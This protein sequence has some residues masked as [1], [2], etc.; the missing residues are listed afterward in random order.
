MVTF[1]E[2]LQQAAESNPDVSVEVQPDEPEPSE[3]VQVAYE[4]SSWRVGDVRRHKKVFEGM[5]GENGKI[6]FIFIN[7]LP[8]TDYYVLQSRFTV[9]FL[10][11]QM[12][13]Q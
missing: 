10:K 9:L 3:A 1:V 5:K 6:S 11:L 13:S 2:S 4:G 12:L 7:S 8:V